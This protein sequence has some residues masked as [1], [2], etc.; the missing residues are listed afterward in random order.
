[1]GTLDLPKEFVA[2]RLMVNARTHHHVKRMRGDAKVIDFGD[3]EELVRLY[4]RSD[5]FHPKI[6]TLQGHAYWWL[7]KFDAAIRAFEIALRL[8]S[9]ESQLSS[10]E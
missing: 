2:Q 4:L 10:L 7:G 6:H 5:M 8:C 1:M 3:R 9:A